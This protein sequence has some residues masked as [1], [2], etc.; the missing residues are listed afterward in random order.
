VF[1]CFFF[2]GSSHQTKNSAHP[3]WAH[4]DTR[5]VIE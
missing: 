5:V 4:V 3:Q 2:D 1:C